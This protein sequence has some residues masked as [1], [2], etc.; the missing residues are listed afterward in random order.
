MLVA[1][2]AIGAIEKRVKMIV[3]KNMLLFEKY[4]EVMV[5]QM[6]DMIKKEVIKAAALACDS[7]EKIGKAE[8]TV[9]CMKFG[10]NKTVKD[11]IA[12]LEKKVG[13]MIDFD[14]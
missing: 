12:F 11:T 4:P 8:F 10:N 13:K 2:S 6:G 9:L 1:L 14:Q 3:V 7:H 5:N